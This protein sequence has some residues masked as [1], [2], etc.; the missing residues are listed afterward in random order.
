[1][2]LPKWKPHEVDGSYGQGLW[3]IFRSLIMRSNAELFV[4]PHLFLSYGEWL[5]LG[6][7]QVA[8][9]CQK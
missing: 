2:R 1:M 5:F 4:E 8:G 7:L 3:D 6:C 9:G